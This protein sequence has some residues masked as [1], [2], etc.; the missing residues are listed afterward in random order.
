MIQNRAMLANLSISR[1]KARKTDKKVSKEV[2]SHH[3]AAA[4][5]G[6]F[7]KT[8]IDKAH[9][10]ALT[11]SESAI[12]AY[13]YKMTLPWDDDG[14]RILPST[15]Y[16][17]YTDAMRE[18]KR[19]DQKLRLDFLAVYP[20]LVS[21]ARQRLGTMYDPADFPD[22]TVI[23]TKFD[24]KIAFEQIP[25]AKDFRVAVSDEAAELIREQISAEN[26]LK[27]QAAMKDCFKR[28]H[29]V[30]SHISETLRQED[31]RIFDSLV[32]NAR[33]LVDCLPGL[34]LTDDPTLEQFRVELHA[35]LPT[36]ESLRASAHVR[37]TTADAADA[38]LAK[39]KH[40][41]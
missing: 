19:I 22:V 40:Y 15:L 7:R 34:N 10:K 37:T 8:L 4:D 16:S 9:L 12:R 5:S 13:H 23:P 6:D 2:T 17:A 41:V 26:D 1:W 27:F 11:S 25:D 30:V 38:I 3:G 35:M 24:I 28:V 21:E 31:P 39:M 29:K 33:D 32:T 20:R 14:R 36:P 18:F